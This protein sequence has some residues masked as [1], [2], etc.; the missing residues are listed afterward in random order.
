M[1]EALVV[2]RKV[3]VACTGS[4]ESAKY[5][6]GKLVLAGAAFLCMGSDIQGLVGLG[7]LL[8]YAVY[9]LYEATV[10]PPVV[11]MQGMGGC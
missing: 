3:S 10:L 11:G 9:A 5:P 6:T 4:D 7:C 2:C 8:A 1:V